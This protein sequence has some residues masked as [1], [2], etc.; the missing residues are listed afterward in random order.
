MRACPEDTLARPVDYF[1]TMPAFYRDPE[2]WRRASA[3]FFA[4]EAQATGF[5]AEYV[6]SGDPAHARCLLDLLFSWAERDALLAYDTE[7]NHGQAWFA[8]QWSAASAGEAN[9]CAT[10]AEDAGS[11][12]TMVSSKSMLRLRATTRRPSVP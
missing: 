4:F 5:A 8:V 7:G 2:G 9:S 11:V 6:R 10:S 12:S 3:P 1:V